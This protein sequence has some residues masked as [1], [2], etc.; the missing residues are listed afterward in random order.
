MTQPLATVRGEATLEGPPELASLSVSVQ[1]SADS[2]AAVRSALARASAE[3]GAALEPHRAAL[4]PA[5]G[6]NLHVAPVVARQGRRMTGYRGSWSTSLAVTDFDA[7]GPLV[8]ALTALDQLQLDGPW[9]SLRSQSPLHRE[10]RLAAVADARRRAEDYAAAFG[11]RVVELLEVSDLEG[12][13]TGSM[14]R[15]YAMAKAMAAEEPE[16][17][18]E[19]AVQ[20]VHGEVTVRFA[21]SPV[22]L[23][24]PA[25]LTG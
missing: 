12:G 9:W 24:G 22:V 21:L 1:R 6:A 19:P 5:G 25:P 14:P 20:S 18:L 11:A 17:D 8:L 10:A 15:R 7:L 13:G 2:A 4:G 16:L 23:A 3:V